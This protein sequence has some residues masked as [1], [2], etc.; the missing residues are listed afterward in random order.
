MTLSVGQS[1]APGYLPKEGKHSYL[2]DHDRILGNE[3][4]VRDLSYLI[5]LVKSNLSAK[6]YGIVLSGMQ[7]R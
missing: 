5:C 3:V 2:T 4:T 7:K 1:C 6:K